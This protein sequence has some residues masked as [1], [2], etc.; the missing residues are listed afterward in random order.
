MQHWSLLKVS[1]R[2][3]FDRFLLMQCDVLEV[4]KYLE[5]MEIVEES[6]IDY[7]GFVNWEWER[8]LRLRENI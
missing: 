1:A 5:E 8:R 2:N 4:R 7:P 6:Y 3:I